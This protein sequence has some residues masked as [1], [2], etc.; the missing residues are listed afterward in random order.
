MN[1]E[2]MKGLTASDFKGG[3]NG[4]RKN[5]TIKQLHFTLSEFDN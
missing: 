3:K 2:M 4:K 1:E 5:T